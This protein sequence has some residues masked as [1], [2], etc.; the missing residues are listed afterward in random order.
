MIVHVLAH[1]ENTPEGQHQI[2]VQVNG[3]KDWTII[4]SECTEK[5][6]KMLGQMSK[7]SRITDF[8]EH[9]I[10]LAFI[11]ERTPEALDIILDGIEAT[12]PDENTPFDDAQLRTE[13]AKMLEKANEQQLQ[14]ILEI[15]ATKDFTYLDSIQTMLSIVLRRISEQKPNP[16]IAKTVQK[17]I[18]QTGIAEDINTEIL[19]HYPEYA[20]ETA[21]ILFNY[22]IT[23]ETIDLL[24]DTNTYQTPEGY[25]IL[26]RLAEL[27]YHEAI[28]LCM[29]I[30]N[31]MD[32]ITEDF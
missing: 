9:N 32:E 16:I 3:W 8:V 27:G 6:G 28:E 5:Y 30:E 22:D 17:I 26:E 15:Y 19:K 10:I 31:T 12:T 18:I 13:V 7:C 11:H 4:H 29:I 23:H 20:L 21:K 1:C 14:R 2:T 25:E 24:R